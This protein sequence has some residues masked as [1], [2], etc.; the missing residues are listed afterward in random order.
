MTGGRWINCNKGD[1]ESPNI[2]SR[3]VAKEV[4]RE[5]APNADFYAATPPLEAKKLLSSKFSSTASIRDP[6]PKLMFIDIKTAY[7]NAEPTRRI[8]VKVPKELGLPKNTVGRL[9]KCC[10]GT[11]DAGMLW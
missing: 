2:R 4:N 6:K 8:Y 10:Y 9:V 11:R 3:Y 7:F 1:N 5:G